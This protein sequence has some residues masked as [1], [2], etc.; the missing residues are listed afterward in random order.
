MRI[1]LSFAPALVAISLT[2][3]CAAAS[4]IRR[5][6]LPDKLRLDIL[7]ATLRH[8]LNGQPLTKGAICYVYVNEG[9][10]K[11][12]EARLTGYRTIVRSGDVGP[13]PPRE[14]WY[15]LDIGKVTAHEAFITIQDAKSGLKLVQLRKR[16]GE[17][18]FV[19]ET[20]IYLTRPGEKM[21]RL[22]HS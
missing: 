10:G 7:E 5:R 22:M 3:T 21:P 12:I 20:S 13:T 19:K 17:W 16:G 11:G 15:W 2:L 6:D 8:K 4:E 1:I 18:I 9:L 14:R